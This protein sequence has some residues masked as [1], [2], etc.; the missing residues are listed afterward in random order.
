MV[1]PSFAPPVVRSTRLRLAPLTTGNDAH[2]FVNIVRSNPNFYTLSSSGSPVLRLEC[3]TPRSSRRSARPVTSSQLGSSL[4]TSTFLRA[5]L[6]RVSGFVLWPLPDFGFGEACNS[7]AQPLGLV[8]THEQVSSEGLPRRHYL[9]VPS[10][11]R[12]SRFTCTPASV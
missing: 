12:Y 7:A 9:R 5:P 8:D 6:S 3:F 10:T 1:G 2:H 11:I 4:T